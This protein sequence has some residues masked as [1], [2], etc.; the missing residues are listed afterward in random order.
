[1]T[2]TQ[3]T[4]LIEVAK[5]LIGVSYKYGAK[6]E[7]APNEFDC[8][9]FTQYIFKHVGI[10]LPRSTILQAECGNAVT[11]ENAQPGDLLFFHGTQG[12]YNEK[13][14]EGIG[15]VI[16]Y[17]GDGKTIHAASQRIQEKPD[18]IERGCVEER[19]LEYVQRRLNT[20]IVIKRL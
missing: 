9:S 10:A 3:K 7:D 8:S 14:P 19:D 4:K 18:I 2:E 16:L 15:H 1:M 13:F 20:L 6:P 5:S 17:I 11:L 12:F